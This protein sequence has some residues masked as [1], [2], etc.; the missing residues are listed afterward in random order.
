M[1]EI[2]RF[3]SLYFPSASARRGLAY[4]PKKFTETLENRDDRLPL[5]ALCYGVKLPNAARAYPFAVL[6]RIDGG[7]V[8][9]EVGGV[10]VV[11][12][13]DR[14]TGSAAGYGRTLDGRSLVFS[15]TKEGLLRDEKSGSVF[16]RDGRS[17]SGLHRNRRLPA[18]TGLQA[19]W[20]GWYAA[21]PDTSIYSMPKK[22]P[23]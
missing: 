2:P 8:N 13:F 7:I 17:V 6:R 22:S 10:P 15:R 12:L 11:I 9:D 16:G 21:Y 20:Y 18:I 3:K 5:N 4:F 1:A 19:E 23:P 14:E